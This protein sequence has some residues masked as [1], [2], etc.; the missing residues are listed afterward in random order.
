M[1]VIIRFIFLL[2]D[3]PYLA[4]NEKIKRLS[5]SYSMT[6]GVATPI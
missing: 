3:L 2:R 5:S 1:L 6:I 4:G